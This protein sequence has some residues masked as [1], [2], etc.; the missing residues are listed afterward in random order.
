[1]DDERVDGWANG[2]MGRRVVTYIPPLCCCWFYF[3]VLFDTYVPPYFLVVVKYMSKLRPSHHL[4]P[5]MCYA[6]GFHASVFLFFL[7]LFSFFVLALRRN[8]QVLQLPFLESGFVVVICSLGIY[9][10]SAILILYRQ[11]GF[12][13]HGS[14]ADSA[15]PAGG[16]SLRF[17]R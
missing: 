1:M 6:R 14:S 4:S 5:S 3:L 15:P 13:L 12:V 10:L 2:W 8:S 11:V 9:H 17:V 7:F 16:A